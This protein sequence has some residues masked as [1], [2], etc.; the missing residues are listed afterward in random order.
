VGGPEDDDGGGKGATLVGIGK[1][2]SLIETWPYVTVSFI[3]Y[4]SNLE[5]NPRWVRVSIV[6]TGGVGSRFLDGGV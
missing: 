2:I 4:Q 3:L 6:G 1:T 5:P